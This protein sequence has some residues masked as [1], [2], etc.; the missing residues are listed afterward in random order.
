MLA[1]PY[2]GVT[3]ALHN[4]NAGVNFPRARG[5]IVAAIT[6]KTETP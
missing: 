6:E 4:G 2:R 5:R 1:Q 3:P